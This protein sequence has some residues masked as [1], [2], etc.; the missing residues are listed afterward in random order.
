MK[1]R[2]DAAI[3]AFAAKKRDAE[4]RGKTANTTPGR[5]M[6][7]GGAAAGPMALQAATRTDNTVPMP[8]NDTAPANTSPLGAPPQGATPQTT[9]MGGSSAVP[10]TDDRYQGA[11]EE[12]R[13]DD[14]WWL[15]GMTVEEFQR[16]GGELS[17]REKN[18]LFNEGVY[19]QKLAELK[20]TVKDNDTWIAAIKAAEE[21]AQKYV[22]WAAGVMGYAIKINP[23]GPEAEDEFMR[24]VRSMNVPMGAGVSGT[25]ARTM[26]SAKMFG[27]D[28][29][30]ARK[31]CVGYL[32]PIQAHS[33]AE[34]MQ[35]SNPFCGQQYAPKPGSD[36]YPQ[37]GIEAEVKAIAEWTKFDDEFNAK[38]IGK[39]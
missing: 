14:T 10:S 12:R 36:N 31:V 27:V 29:L 7:N 21:E 32:L 1:E 37:G 2:K 11:T 4:L 17:A 9:A 38:A 6:L 19:R 39:G 25:T 23:S 30:Q 13:E 8:W 18:Q 35:A 22:P 28:G 5:E 34:V 26:N 15:H 16:L 33:F 20:P 3:A 24:A